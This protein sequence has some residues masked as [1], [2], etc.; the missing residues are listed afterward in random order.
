MRAW[1]AHGTTISVAVNISTR[2]LQESFL[3]GTRRHDA[4]EVVDRPELLKLE[5]TESALLADPD[6]VIAM[7][8]AGFATSG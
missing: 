5:I 4:R 8:C 1:K 3:R 7:L 6:R 2:I